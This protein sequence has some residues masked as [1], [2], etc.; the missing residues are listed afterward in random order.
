MRYLISI[1]IFILSSTISWTQENFIMYVEPQIEVEHSVNNL[2]SIN[3][4]VENRNLLYKNNEQQFVV[5][6]IDIGH[7]SQ[8]E[9]SVNQLIG[10]GIKY[11][12]KKV[13]NIN[14]ENELRLLQVYKWKNTWHNHN[15]KNRLRTE[16][17]FY[18]STFK[19][20]LRYELGTAFLINQLSN[21][22]IK[23][24]T[25]A[26]FEIAKTQKPE[27]EQRLTT[28]Y[29]FKLKKD[30]VV[31]VGTQYRLADYTQNLNHELFLV[32]K[33]EIDL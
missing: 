2:Y 31:E 27:Y 23:L 22:Y 17:R 4:S 28:L 3:F 7:V 14:E 18:K 10:V 1:L 8:F 13:F 33:L 24:E 30:K 32:L 5:K 29:G 6:Q 9:L 15:I 20:R 19:N 26:L 16:Q 12:F 11:R 21:S 25:E